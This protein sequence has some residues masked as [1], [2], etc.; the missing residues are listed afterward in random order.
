[1]A[2]GRKVSQCGRGSKPPLLCWLA[3][4]RWSPTALC[5]ACFVLFGLAQAR[6]QAKPPATPP[7]KPSA[8]STEAAAAVPELVFRAKA[9]DFG[10][11]PPVWC[12]I[13]AT[14]QWVRF[15]QV[16]V[17]RGTWERASILVHCHV[18]AKAK[19]SRKDGE[20]GLDPSFFAGTCLVS[21]SLTLDSSTGQYY[22]LAQ[23]VVPGGKRGDAPS[24]ETSVADL[25]GAW[26]GR[27][28]SASVNRLQAPVPMRF[29]LGTPGQDGSR[30][31]TLVYGAPGPKQS[32]RRYHLVVTPKPGR[33]VLDENNGIWMDASFVHGALWTRFRV[34]NAD[35]LVS[36]RAVGRR[37]LATFVTTTKEPS[38]R[39]GGDGKVP[40]VPSFAVL[41]VQR[42]VLFKQD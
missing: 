22:W 36:Y 27:L 2:R 34:G 19:W 6:A 20:V 38:S 21:A 11:A 15:A 29:E 16:E 31:F 5:L 12:G 26:T 33:Y 35:L 40:E 7:S 28:V 3:V 23:D 32:V 4:K 1:M 37:L 41:S 9:E 17:L 14:R 30:A 13:V 24:L 10:K 39:S 8:K 25:E 42:A 18:I